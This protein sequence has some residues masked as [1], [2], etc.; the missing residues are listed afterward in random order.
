MERDLLRGFL[1]DAGEGEI[2]ERDLVANG[3]GTGDPNSDRGLVHGRIHTPSWLDV[4][5]VSG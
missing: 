3:E 4:R 1:V 5:T 2:D